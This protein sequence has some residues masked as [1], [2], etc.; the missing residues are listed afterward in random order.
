MNVQKP[1][2]CCSFIYTSGTTGLP[3]AVMISH[4]N[5]TWTANATIERF[6]FNRP[7]KMGNG[8]ML[9]LL[10]LS[11]VAA[12]MVDLVMALQM[13]FSLYFPDPSALQGNLVKF[14]Q[15]SRP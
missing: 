8:R 2:N 12:Q 13:G 1:G 15:V 14:L 11:H 5:F 4:D 10:P 6:N 7:E 3:K 9:S